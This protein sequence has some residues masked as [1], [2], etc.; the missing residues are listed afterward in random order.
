MTETF[1]VRPAK[2]E[3]ADFIFTMIQEIAAYERM[4]NEVTAT[5]EDIVREVFQRKSAYAL[6]AQENG[7]SIGFALYFFHFSTFQGRRGL[8]LEDVFLRPQYRG[9]GYGSQML[10]ELARIA[11]EQGC[12]RMEWSCLNWNQPSIAFYLGLGAKPMDEWTVYRL[13][14]DSLNKL[15]ERRNEHRN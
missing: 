2:E 10:Q 7:V 14:G 12:G 9:K 15:A 11:V 5:R 8:Y 6:I 13:T 1:C 3:D 4:S